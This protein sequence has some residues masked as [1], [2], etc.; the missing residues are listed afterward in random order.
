MKAKIDPQTRKNKQR[1]LEYRKR[2]AFWVVAYGI[3][4]RAIELRYFGTSSLKYPENQT[5]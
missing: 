1:L 3:T 2:M 4:H 5:Y